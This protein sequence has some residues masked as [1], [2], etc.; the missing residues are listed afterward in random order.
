MNLV[1][2]ADDPI[3]LEAIR[4]ALPQ[5]RARLPQGCHLSVRFV[6][7]PPAGGVTAGQADGGHR[8]PGGPADLTSRQWDILDQLVTGLSNK[9]IGRKLDLSHFT[10]RNHISQIMRIVGVSTRQELIV[11]IAAGAERPAGDRD[12]PGS[13]ARGRHDL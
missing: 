12:L 9:E 4:A 6:E 5:V 7:A 2:E 1:I 8:A 3:F 11:A 10:V 13:G